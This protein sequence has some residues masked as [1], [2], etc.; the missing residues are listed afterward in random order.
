MF[1]GSF[2]VSLLLN[3]SMTSSTAPRRTPAIVYF[4]G[5][6]AA[7]AGLLF[8]LDVGVISGALPFLR[9]EFSLS[10]RMAEFVVAALLWGAVF[11]TLISGYLSSHFG[12][13][14]TMLF[15][16]VNFIVGAIL[17]SL[18]PSEHLLIGARF[19]L[20]IAVGVASFTAPLYLSEISPQIVRGSL[21][22]MYQLMITIGIVLAFLSNTWL[23]SYA[24]IGG[25]VG[26]H[27]RWMLGVIALP[28]AVMFIGVFLL[29]ES[30]RWLFLKGF[31]DRGIAILRRLHLS[32]TDVAIAFAVS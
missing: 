25:V 8:G 29:P 15:S 22:S 32:E 3:P 28:A 24:N 19:I 10:T 2:P 13:R 1:P 30:P 17:C 16:A 11:G 31:R 5:F 7:L 9:T 18:S 6:T 21:I 20:G 23:A 4:I 12:R 26:G 14:K 27:W